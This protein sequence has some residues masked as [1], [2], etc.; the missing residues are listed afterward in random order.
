MSIGVELQENF[1]I[2]IDDEKQKL[3]DN[4]NEHNIKY[5]ILYDKINKDNEPETII[6][7]SDIDTELYFV[8]NLL[9]KIKMI[10]N[11][12]TNILESGA[13]IESPL[14]FIDKVKSK[15]D[16]LCDNKSHSIKIERIDLNSMNCSFIVK[17]NSRKSRIS[18]S[19]DT[20]GNVFLN[21]IRNMN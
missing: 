6:A 3:V 11:T 8:N 12:Q 21:T 15:I 10:N 18:I 17:M 5:R 14:D 7:L 9:N 16:I 19:R 13:D 1:K 4:L 20:R 2:Y